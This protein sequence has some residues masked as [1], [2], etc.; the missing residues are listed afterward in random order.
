M[1]SEGFISALHISDEDILEI[2]NFAIAEKYLYQNKDFTWIDLDAN[3]SNV[4]KWLKQHLKL[5]DVAVEALTA[6]E[7]QPRIQEVSK[8]R[9][10]IILR[11]INSNKKYDPEDMVSV[12]MYVSRNTIVT[13]TWRRVK[14]LKNMKDRIQLTKSPANAG[15]FIVSLATL[16]NEHLANFLLAQLDNLDEY[17]ESVL[18]SPNETLRDPVITLRKQM[19]IF[20]RYTIPQKV[21]LQNLLKNNLNFFTDEDRARLDEAFYDISRNLEDIDAIKDRSMLVQDE[22]KNHFAEKLNRNT[23]AFSLLAGIF[24]PLSF[25]TG[26]LGVNLHGI[27]YATSSF[28]FSGFCAILII[29]LIIQIIIFKYKDW[30]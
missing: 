6:E 15:Q 25:F 9:Y 28:A 18:E 10:M 7:T 8:E 26:L 1:S 21:V 20:K 23:Y 5:N 30:F 16:F 19:I 11:G 12:R 29:V 24:L 3:S 14:A 13:L 2:D 4:K 27:P 22:I 17:E